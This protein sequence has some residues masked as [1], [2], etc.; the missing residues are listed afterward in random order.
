MQI[1]HERWEHV[2]I[3][4]NDRHGLTVK[5]SGHSRVFSWS[6]STVADAAAAMAVPEVSQDKEDAPT[7]IMALEDVVEEE[8]DR[9]RDEREIPDVAGWARRNE[10]PVAEFTGGCSEEIGRES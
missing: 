3:Y 1:R 7:P 10:G 2:E 4:G 9:S 5:H 8:R 6:V